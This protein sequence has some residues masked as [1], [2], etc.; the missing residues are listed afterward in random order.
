MCIC[1]SVCLAIDRSLF[2]SFSI[3]FYLSL[4]I[5][6][7]L[8]SLFG[9]NEPQGAVFE[10]ILIRKQFCISPVLEHNYIHVTMIDWHDSRGW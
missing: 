8:A 6:F 1:L 3:F 4:F 5:Y 2:L 10:V 7:F 9:A